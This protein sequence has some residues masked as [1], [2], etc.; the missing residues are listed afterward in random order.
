VWEGAVTDV[1][2]PGLGP[3]G[4]AE[5]WTSPATLPAAAAA[6]PTTAQIMDSTDDGIR[7]SLGDAGLVLAQSQP[8][9]EAPGE[10]AGDAQKED[11]VAIQL[12]NPISSLISV[13]FQQNIQFGIGPKNA[14]W[15]DLMNIQPV[16]PFS[17]ND[18]WN[19]VARMIMPVVYQNDIFP[20][21]GSQFGIGDTNFQF[22]FSPKAT[23]SSGLIW[24]IGPTFYVPS[25]MYL[26]STNTWGAG[27]D[28][29]VLKQAPKKWMNG[30][31]LT[32]GILVTQLWPFSGPAPLN[33]VFLQPFVAYTLKNTVTFNLQSQA[34]YNWT[35]SQ[36]TVPVIGSVSKIFKFGDQL[37]SL[38]F[39]LKYYPV[40]P[41][42]APQWGVQLVVTLL[43]P[44]K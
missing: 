26:L 43:F 8:P 34:T 22:F 30:G 44:S 2:S 23:T 15:Q 28:G 42:T 41:V 29:V 21:A 32:Y 9:N 10:A 1:R 16:V 5:V 25:G 4:P 14:G 7:L 13:P 31:I 24:G 27:L 37:T 6:A 3:V 36:W 38:A 17:L 19:L 20:G 11:N 18:T 33:S 39:G 40:R 35:Q 12:A